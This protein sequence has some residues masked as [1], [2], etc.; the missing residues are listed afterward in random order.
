MK[1]YVLSEMIPEKDLD[2][3]IMGVVTDFA[4]SSAFISKSKQLENGV[5]R[6][7]ESAEFND[8]SFLD[9]IAKENSNVTKST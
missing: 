9:R 2:W 7:W 3:K 1:V 5:L 4:I 6:K 8:P